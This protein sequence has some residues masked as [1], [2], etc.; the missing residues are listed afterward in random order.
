VAS[1]S[2]AKR[3]LLAARLNGAAHST[4][5][6]VSRAE[7]L[8]PIQASF[9]QRRLWFLDQLNP[10]SLAY[11]NA[12][13]IHLSGA[14]NDA[15]V[16]DAVRR[17]VQRHDALRTRFIQRDGIPLLEVAP[18][19]EIDVPL[20]DL[21]ALAADESEQAVRRLS[22]EAARVPFDLSAR[23][24][25]RFRLLKLAAEQYVLVYVVHH[26]ISDR[27]SVGIFVRELMESLGKA[28]M[29][30]EAPARYA[31]YAAWQQSASG[32]V[33]ASVQFWRETLTPLPP[34][35]ELPT[36]HSRPANQS[37]RGCVHRVPL[38]A[39]LTQSIAKLARQRG[40]T[41]FA[42][43]L[44]AFEVF[45][46]RYTGQDDAVL[47]TVLA[48]RN[49]LELEQAIGLFVNV[50]PV[51][52]RIHGDTPFD[53]IVATT[54][55]AMLGI[56]D[57]QEL[58]F[59]SL[60]DELHAPRDPGRSPLFQIV[61]N[62]HNVP[63]PPRNVNGL[64]VRVEDIDTGTSRF[65]LTLTI[66][67]QAEGAIASFEYCRDLFEPETIE[68]MGE[69]FL[70]L[71]DGIVDDPS[72]PVRQLPL[73]SARQRQHLLCDWNKDAIETPPERCVH[74]L[75]EE[76]AH[77]T[78]DATALICG[79][80]RFTYAEVN[81]R[82]NQVAHHLR[83]MGVRPE[84]LVGICLPRT[85][86]LLPAIV[87][88]LKCGGAY[89]PLDPEYPPQRIAFML[90]D[91]RCSVLVTEMSVLASLPFA[92][93]KVVCVDR[94]SEAIARQS[95]ND[96]PRVSRPHHLAYVI[97]T[98]GSTGKPKGVAIEHRAPASLARWARSA[99]SDR[100]MFRMLAVASVC[101]D[102]SI[103][104][105][106][107][108]L[109]RGGAVIL[110][111]SGLHLGESRNRDE[112]T[113]AFLVPSVCAEILR[114]STLPRNLA[115]IALG[116]EAVPEML[117]R[118]CHEM[119]IDAVYNLYGPTEDTVISLGHRISR[120]ASGPPPI[121]KSI[122]GGRAYIL[123]P[124]REPVPIGVPGELYL[125]GVKVARGYLARP[126][127]TAERF[128][129]DPFD[130]PG[131]TLYRT[132]DLCRMR[133]DGN[134]Q[135]I[136]R[137]DHQIKIRGFRIELGE[138]ES[139]LAQHPA[140]RQCAVNVCGEGADRRLVA[141]FTTTDPPPAVQALRSHLSA[142]LPH[143]MMPSAFVRLDAMPLNASGK[144]DRSLLAGSASRQIEG[145][146]ESGGATTTLQRQL[147]EIWTNLLGVE[148][149]GLDD[150]FFELGGHSLRAVTMVARIQQALG[151][152]VPVRALFE[153]PTIAA[154]SAFMESQHPITR[155]PEQLPD[156][157]GEVDHSL[158]PAQRTLWFE[159]YLAGQ[160]GLY[161]VTVARRL[162]GMLDIERL[163]QALNIVIHRHE[164][165]RTCFPSED[166][167]PSRKIAPPDGSRVRIDIAD[168]RSL[169]NSAREVEVERVVERESQAP[170][171]LDQLPLLRAKL[172][173]LADAECILILT[174]H[175][176]VI[177]D[178]SI[179]ILLDE[180]GQAYV[181]HELLPPVEGQS[182][183]LA[184][185]FREWMASPEAETQLEYW[186]RQL[187]GAP[188]LLSLP[189]DRPRPATQTF[190]GARESVQLPPSVVRRL[191]ELANSE[192]A[193]T[194]MA[195]FAAFNVLLM[196]WSG[197]NDFVIGSPTANREDPASH[198]H[199]GYFLNMLPLRAKLSAELS[200]REALRRVRS[201]TLDAFDHQ[202]F[203]FEALVERLRPQR[204]ASFTPWMQ[205]IFVHLT[206]GPPR[207]NL[208]G[209]RCEPFHISGPWAKCDLSLLLNE[210]AGQIEGAMEYNCDLFD[211]AT[212]KHLVE[213]FEM[214]VEALLQH[215]DD[216]LGTLGEPMSSG[217]RQPVS[218][219]KTQPDEARAPTAT[220]TKLKRIWQD[221]LGV[222]E[223][224]LYDDFFEHG[225][226]SFLVVRVLSQIQKEFG[227]TLL[228][229]S[230]FEASTIAS[231]GA[232]IDGDSQQATD[233]CH[234]EHVVAFRTSGAGVPLFL[235]PGIDGE[236]MVFRNFV[237]LLEADRPVY[238][239]QLAHIGE[240]DGGAPS[241][242]KIAA[243]AI[244]RMQ[245]V[246]PRGP[247]Y[248]AGYSF[249]G[250]VAYEMAQQLLRAGHQVGMLG[251]IDSFPPGVI[252][253]R[254]FIRRL[255]I[256]L[257]HL[258]G[259]GPG[260]ARRHL[261]LVAD[262]L[263][264]RIARLMGRDA[265]PAMEPRLEAIAHA[266]R[267]AYQGYRPVPYCGDV[268]LFCAL[269]RIGWQDFSGAD[270]LNG[271]TNLVRGELVVRQLD[272]THWTV[273]EEPHLQKLA[274][275]FSD[276]LKRRT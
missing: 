220:E 216:A 162:T 17:I 160:S 88:I 131:S 213:R 67:P 206:E 276:C 59:D 41:P 178:W 175:H 223:I 99:F 129:P 217:L 54:R 242:E 86:R 265:K 28:P 261:R 154:L 237:G 139:V 263:S 96:P 56:L 84:A 232:L 124:N 199:I 20:V 210:N 21:S 252:R 177:D 30:S 186:K 109:T 187:A 235:L 247:Y 153:H 174:I 116:G 63:P 163:E 57:H 201:V 5:H 60:V 194:F 180:I 181:G 10:G 83:A 197:E 107:L 79:S 24:L 126:E 156:R 143:Y 61:F 39:S 106:F 253:S 37:S 164:M 48:T 114:A 256:H 183:E 117:A 38:P 70:T 248:L 49:Q 3:R 101:F 267:S 78:P 142:Q 113:F 68:R 158:S 229:G 179:R 205:V 62:Y 214:L 91:S 266:A 33:D 66:S 8:G 134:I 65:D 40:A 211:P 4:L 212:I 204:R 257:F 244:A 36:D 271:W 254:S 102:L 202:A 227:R 141:Y 26:I 168:V 140:V 94:D 123:G 132:G 184:A 120:D 236:T 43:M 192:R 188:A 172:I 240:E 110:E 32:D 34:P 190:R 203:P 137:I 245:R 7:H 189:T 15:D 165:L 196:K 145:P 151:L 233:Q 275:H 150:N 18:S 89:L 239:L 221:V 85:S 149:I 74:E 171:A 125:G 224:G 2:D 182:A 262:R 118:R 76:Q 234:P 25:V 69:N 195:L 115:G 176:I 222:S 122:G 169:A 152:S 19:L 249:G 46:F 185:H 231:M 208:P 81:R 191:H 53:E 111:A 71:L 173:R 77:R 270:E 90:E 209:V 166:G 228:L 260:G 155:G 73:L 104:E 167:A 80:E 72:Q 130:R 121:G 159:H 147:T 215:P 108:P 127:L 112:A 157:S 87:G 42:V 273:F 52:C 219:P 27:W 82:A 44:A 55:T 35:F 12:N 198:G 13:T 264:M 161:N 258:F 103:F 250:M 47:G 100:E 268:V 136:S 200:F 98:S 22:I 51:R 45:L 119:G 218:D 251:L 14:L 133:A 23:P 11:N 146:L 105:F 64:E 95:S 138:V 241:M 170:F 259:E 50:L 29:S 274:G 230:M 31:D 75:F 16:C 6:T 97:Y 93:P 272:A 58:P 246:Q 92:P 193:T 128:I 144:V 269:R 207:L 243:G 9:A 225:G 255:P 226:H 1:L 148:S 135:F 238:G